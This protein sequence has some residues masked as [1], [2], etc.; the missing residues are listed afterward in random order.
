MVIEHVN[1]QQVGDVVLLATQLTRVIALVTMHHVF[2]E[3]AFDLRLELALWTRVE[4]SR[5]HPLQMF[6][7]RRLPCELGRAALLRAV[8]LA[9]HDDTLRTL[10]AA[11]RVHDDPVLR[12]RAPIRKR[13]ATPAALVD[14]LR[15]RRLHLDPQP[16]CGP[17]GHTSSPSSRRR[18]NGR[19]A[20]GFAHTSVNLLPVRTNDVC[21][22]LR[23]QAEAFDRRFRRTHPAR[24]RT[25]SAAQQQCSSRKRLSN[26]DQ[27]LA[28]QL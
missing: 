7:Q 9:V 12:Q 4:H 3:E 17:A 23:P 10:G 14:H 11:L 25:F 1:A 24:E 19:A 15:E 27:I 21:G 20:G 18:G 22:E 28:C 16:L 26:P 5:V 13:N 6:D 8:V 2:S